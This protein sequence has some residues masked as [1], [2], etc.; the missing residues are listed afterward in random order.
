MSQASG[1]VVS[2]SNK[3]CNIWQQLNRK[4]MG[5]EK[6]IVLETESRIYMPKNMGV[7]MSNRKK[8]DDSYS[9]SLQQTCLYYQLLP[10]TK[11]D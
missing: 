9:V 6:L 8:E 4:S 2:Y 10:I 1:Q 7:K 11:S 3:L 5:E